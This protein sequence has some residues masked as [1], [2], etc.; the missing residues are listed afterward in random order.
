MELTSACSFE[1]LEW[2]SWTAGDIPFLEDSTNDEMSFRVEGSRFD[3]AESSSGRER[4]GSM[5]AGLSGVYAG[6]SDSRS[7]ASRVA[8][9]AAESPNKSVMTDTSCS[10]YPSRRSTSN[11]HLRPAHF[12]R[13][14]ASFED[15]LLRFQFVGPFHFALVHPAILEHLAVDGF[16][17]LDLW[18]RDPS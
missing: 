12:D 13:L 14:D 4:E 7:E 10:Q 9:S 16:F 11:A 2:R 15:P 6:L 8:V 5:M 3:K 17:P 18:V 1:H